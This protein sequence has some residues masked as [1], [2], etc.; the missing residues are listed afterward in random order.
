MYGKLVLSWAAQHAMLSILSGV[1]A[2]AVLLLLRFVSD[3]DWGF[4]RDICRI[5]SAYLVQA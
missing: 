1:D 5:V 4:C 2:L 3:D